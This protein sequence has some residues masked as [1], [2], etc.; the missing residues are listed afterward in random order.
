[1]K[2]GLRTKGEPSSRLGNC[3]YPQP[4]KATAALPGSVSALPVAFSP[5]SHYSAGHTRGR[6]AGLL[7]DLGVGSWI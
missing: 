5:A 6:I 3:T 7:M 2:Q 1:M 4:A